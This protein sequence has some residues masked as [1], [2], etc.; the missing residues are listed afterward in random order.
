MIKI[1]L[2]KSFG[3]ESSEVVKSV[4]DQKSKQIGFIKNFF[5]MILGILGLFIYE[6]FNI[7]N[8]KEQQV[9]LQAQLNELTSF[10]QKKEA[11][12]T[13]I[14]KYENDR[15]RLN[16]QTDFLQKIQKE[17]TLTVEFLT[18]IRQLI[19]ANVWIVSIKIDGRTIEI[20][21]EADSERE[22]NEF[23]LKLA[24][25]PFLKDVI[26]QSIEMSQQTPDT[27]IATK[28][29]SMRASFNEATNSTG[30]GGKL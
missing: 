7:P 25:L 11:L 9:K 2:L 26:V 15:V 24:S 29:F 6:Q 1:N 5:V 12:K 30:E 16:R 28:N 17:R 3:A 14:E 21:G 27:K 22:I 20:K 23:N 4:E 10:N 18:K 13:E 8:L 19:P